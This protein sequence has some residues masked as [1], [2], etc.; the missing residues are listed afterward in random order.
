M[1]LSREPQDEER[2]GGGGTAKAGEPPRPGRVSPAVAVGRAGA[3]RS[4]RRL[5]GRGGGP[6]GAALDVF[7][8]RWLSGL[9]GSR[10]AGVGTG[11]TG[12]GRCPPPRPAS[13]D[14]LAGCCGGR[15][16]R[17]TKPT[18]LTLG[19]TQA[20]PSPRLES[21][22]HSWGDRWAWPVGHLG[23]LRELSAGGEVRRKRPPG[24]GRS[25]QRAVETAPQLE[26][27]GPAP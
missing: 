1:F 5:R 18:G 3:G 17:V 27:R 11:T 14:Q 8:L 24:T 20:D 19:P 15:G 13:P 26:G 16:P 21:P 22:D 9:T 25:L 10:D 12:K 23:H 4:Q 2:G 7:T 6:G